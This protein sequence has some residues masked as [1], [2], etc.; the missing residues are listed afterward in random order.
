MG[1]RYERVFS[2][3]KR[4]QY[5]EGAPVVIAAGALLKDRQTGG[6][7]AQLKFR[8]I[9]PVSIKALAAKVF[10]GDLSGKPLGGAA[11]HLYLDLSIRRGEEFGQKQAIPLPDAATRTFSVRVTEVVFEDLSTWTAPDI[12]W[13]PLPEKVLAKTVIRH[14]LMEQY[15]SEY[16][17]RAEYL[18]WRARDVR[19]CPCGALNLAEE[20]VCY[21]CGAKEPPADFGVETLQEHWNALRPEREEKAR[22]EARKKKRKRGVLA[23]VAALVVV[24]AAWPAIKNNIPRY[25]EPIVSQSSEQGE[26]S[27][28]V[29]PVSLNQIREELVGKTFAG[30]ACVGN[31]GANTDRVKLRFID[32]TSGE[33]DYSVRKRDGSLRISGYKTITYT[34]NGD[35]DITLSWDD[36][37]GPVQPFRVVTQENRITLETAN[38]RNEVIMILRED[39][40]RDN[41]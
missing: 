20:P 28:P 18:P 16:G 41:G 13:E 3:P 35:G 27:D 31:N 38:W 37:T 21:A 22:R 30:T 17:L 39:T 14:E 6:I 5:L 34:L 40:S 29:I 1:E 8:N 24:V 9:R 26:A 11:E 12:P 32:G 4:E 33:I 19:L 36:E 25:P 23:A 7:L 2:L 15:L 10:P